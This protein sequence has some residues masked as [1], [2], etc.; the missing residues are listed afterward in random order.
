MPLATRNTNLRKFEVDPGV[1]V[2]LVS[3]KAGGV[4]L[5]LACA[6]HVFMMDPYWNP[7]I[8][9]QAIDR[10]H[11]LG[12][13][14]IV[15][16]TRYVIK[17]SIEERIMALQE[18]KSKVIEVSLLDKKRLRRTY[19]DPGGRL[20]MEEDTEDEMSS[21]LDKTL[22]TKDSDIN[23]GIGQALGGKTRKERIEQLQ[24][25]FSGGS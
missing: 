13:T 12:Q 9:R 2:F 3:L 24:F 4:G 15:T 22:G 23:G 10:I 25:L 18:R 11:R 7:G 8:E 5:N 19:R 21:A 16:V 20:V 1:T 17:D 14:R 6:T